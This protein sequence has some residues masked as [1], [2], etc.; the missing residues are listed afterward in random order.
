[1]RLPDMCWREVARPL[2]L[3]KR[4]AELLYAKNQTQQKSKENDTRPPSV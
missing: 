1:M 4:K 3:R 2:R